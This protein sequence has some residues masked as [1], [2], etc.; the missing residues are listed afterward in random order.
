MMLIKDADF[1]ELENIAQRMEG[2]M[3]RTV[4]ISILRQ[5]RIAPEGTE[6]TCN[7]DFQKWPDGREQCVKCGEFKA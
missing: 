2:S 1:E 6:G 7:H 4:M 5:A 3:D